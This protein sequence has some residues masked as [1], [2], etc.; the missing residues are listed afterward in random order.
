MVTRIDRILREKR[1]LLLSLDEGIEEGPKAFSLTTVDPA[2]ILNIAIEGEY[3]GIIVNPGI[4]EKYLGS[5]SRDVPIIINLNAKGVMEGLDPAGQLIC[6]VERAVKLGAQAVAFTLYDGSTVDPAIFAEFGR[7]VEHAHDYGI[8]VVAW[9]YPKRT[10]EQNNERDAY[11]ARLALELG[12]DAVGVR[13]SGDVESFSW[14]VKCAG[15]TAVFAVEG[16]HA[17]PK[18][19]LTHARSAI[20]AGA[21]GVIHGKSVW[22]HAKPF[23][24]TRAMHAV[25]FKDKTIEDALKYV[26]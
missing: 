7:V 14:L 18:D 3:T 25:V 17:T 12:A 16:P 24:L 23:S 13:F 19:I 5:L 26:E 10:H 22:S 2:Y 21:S 4:A 8:P 20:H 6:T 11:A 15:K 1:A 9:M